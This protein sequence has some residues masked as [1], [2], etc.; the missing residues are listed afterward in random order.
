[1]EL[2][3]NMNNMEDNSFIKVFWIRHAFEVEHGS[4]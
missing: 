3:M 2:Q 1:M 4:L